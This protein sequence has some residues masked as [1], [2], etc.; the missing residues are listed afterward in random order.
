MLCSVVGVPKEGQQLNG[1]TAAHAEIT[2]KV[3]PGASRGSTC[4]RAGCWG[5]ELGQQRPPTGAV[6]RP[7]LT[8]P[9]QH[10]STASPSS[11]L[12][13]QGPHLSCGTQ[14]PSF[15]PP[16][17]AGSAK[18]AAQG[19][20]RFYRAF[21]SHRMQHVSLSPGVVPWVFPTPQAAFSLSLQCPARR[22]A[23]PCPELL[24]AHRAEPCRARQA[25]AR[26]LS[27]SSHRCLTT[28][29]VFFIKGVFAGERGLPTS[30]A[31]SCNFILNAF[32]FCT[33]TSE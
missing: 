28:E 30:T 4:S 27:P 13:E 18:G 8:C 23:A 22:G 19:P 14:H 9:A 31:A 29:A 2:G 1:S 26:G 25:R 11:E 16:H 21:P 6:L 24:P 7:L 10:H 20:G 12:S 32:V 17:R 33:F 3:P 5:A 15:Q